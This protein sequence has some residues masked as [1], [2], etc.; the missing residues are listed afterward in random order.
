MAK[1]KITLTLFAIFSSFFNFSISF[2]SSADF[3]SD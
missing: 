2:R 3:S 1:Q